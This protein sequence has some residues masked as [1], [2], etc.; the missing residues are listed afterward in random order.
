MAPFKHVDVQSVPQQLRGKNMKLYFMSLNSWQRS[1]TLSVQKPFPGCQRS[2]G[3]ERERS[4]AEGRSTVGTALRQP[5]VVSVDPP[6]MRNYLHWDPFNLG[7]PALSLHLSALRSLRLHHSSG[8]FLAPGPCISRSICGNPDFGRQ[9]M[10]P[11]PVWFRTYQAPK[12]D[13]FWAAPSHGL[14]SAEVSGCRGGLT[15]FGT[16]VPQ[17][18]L[19]AVL[20]RNNCV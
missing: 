20:V 17:T 5:S 10:F 14:E 2:S 16:Q 3:S 19:D 6:W 4:P 18:R 8:G 15:R 7:E 13:R 12:P 1:L 9:P 11:P